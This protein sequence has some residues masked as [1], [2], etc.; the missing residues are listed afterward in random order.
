[1]ANYSTQH[2]SDL[3]RALLASEQFAE[4]KLAD[5]AALACALRA[6][7]QSA[8]AKEAYDYAVYMSKADAR[9]AEALK[10]SR[11]EAKLLASAPRQ[12]TGEKP[13]SK[14]ASWQRASKPTVK[15]ASRQRAALRRASEKRAALRRASE[16]H[17]ASKRVAEEDDADLAQALKASK[18][19]FDNAD[20]TEDDEDDADLAQV[21]KASKRDF[22]FADFTEDEA[23][24]EKSDEEKDADEEYRVNQCAIRTISVLTGLTMNEV[25]GIIKSDCDQQTI[26]DLHAGR[27]LDTEVFNVVG[28]VIKCAFAMY[29]YLN[30][31]Q[32]V[33][34]G[35]VG[36]VW[37][38]E[39]FEYPVR[40]EPFGTTYEEM[41]TAK[42]DPTRGD[43]HW[44]PDQNPTGEIV[45][46]PQNW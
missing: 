43:G 22:D 23:K 33:F 34:V 42:T 25:I 38:D 9:A 30:D 39:S 45:A 4:A 18:R 36:H 19:A 46:R 12:D 28:N 11:Y 29:V 41:A 10:Y 14:R 6:S 44:E 35:L 40:W 26:D 31:D 17:A 5:D 21:L 15:R 13:A 8:D 7:K 27:P 20:F 1:M 3:E 32:K 24:Y 37:C 16:K 2:D